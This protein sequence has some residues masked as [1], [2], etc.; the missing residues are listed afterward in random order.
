MSLALID[1]NEVHLIGRL[2][3]DPV[4]KTMPSGDCAVNFRI[5]VRR[6]P[7]A[8]RRQNID[9][10]ECTSYRAA[11][12]KASA[13]WAPGDVLEVH[14][15]LHRRFWR[16]EFGTRSAYVVDVRTV[17]RVSRAPAAKPRRRTVRAEIA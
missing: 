16:G 5:V 11:T 8:V 2:A 1:T 17:R 10:I 4:H 9:S 12:L 13:N 6:P 15:A 3:E 14:G 7:A